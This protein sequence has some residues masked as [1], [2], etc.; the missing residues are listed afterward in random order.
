MQLTHNEKIVGSSPT[1]RTYLKLKYMRIPRKEKKKLKKWIKEHNVRLSL[2][3][4][5]WEREHSIK[6]IRMIYYDLYKERNNMFHN[7]ELIFTTD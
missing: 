4:Y 1:G 5:P 3:D 7:S 2:R 6:E